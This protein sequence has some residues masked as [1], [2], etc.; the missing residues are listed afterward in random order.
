VKKI[1]IF[2]F[3]MLNLTIFC[4]AVEKEPVKLLR[5]FDGDTIEVINEQDERLVIRL[6]G[7]DCFETTN[8]KRAYK[9]AYENKISLEEVV[10]RGMRAKLFLIKLF[11]ENTDKKLYIEQ[12]GIDKY[13]RILAIVY[14]GSININDYML[15]NNMAM[16]YNYF[17]E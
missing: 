16:K 5:V 17:M 14:V 3:L 10:S 2:I 4:S 7:I 1:F 9:Q 6:I 8:N 12:F 15:K 13:K 11:K